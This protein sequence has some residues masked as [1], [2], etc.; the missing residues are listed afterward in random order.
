[1]K[2]LNGAE[3]GRKEGTKTKTLISHMAPRWKRNFCV[4]GKFVHEFLMPTQ[5]IAICI[6]FSSI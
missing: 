5:H 3:R 4:K 2:F 6:N 1:M